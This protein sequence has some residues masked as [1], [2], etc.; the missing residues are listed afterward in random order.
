MGEVNQKVNGKAIE[1]RFLDGSAR[2]GGTAVSR[3]LWQFRG[4][5]QI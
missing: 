1:M 5:G 4:I 2:S 3:G